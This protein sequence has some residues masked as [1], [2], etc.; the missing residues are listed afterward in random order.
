MPRQ[1]EPTPDIAYYDNGAVRFRGFQLDGEMHDSWEF[2]CKDGSP[3]RSGEFDR[4]RQIGIWRTYDR[5]GKVV[6]ETDF[7][8]RR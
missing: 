5:A 4:G 7:S 2:F 6:K 1:S 8:K 3:M